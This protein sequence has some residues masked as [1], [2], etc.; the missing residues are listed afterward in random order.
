MSQDVEIH[1]ASEEERL[2]AYRNVYE[3][4]GGA[5]TLDE[6]LSRRLQSAA[7]NHAIWWV[8]KVGDQVAASLGAH[9]LE[10]SY[11]GR[12]VTGFGIAAVHTHPDHR[13]HGHAAELCRE[14][15]RHA[16]GHG[17]KLGLLFSDIDPDYY[18][19]LGYR[20]C[21]APRYLCE[22]P[23][24][25][26]ESGPLANLQPIKPA[27]ELDRLASWYDACHRKQALSIHRSD[28]YWR[29]LCEKNASA[30]YLSVGW[31]GAPA[32]GYVV[33][34]RLG[35]EDILEILELVVSDP[36]L[37]Q[38]TY[39]AA[40]QMTLERGFHRVGGWLH[41][42]IHHLNRFTAVAREKALPMLLPLDDDMTLDDELLQKGCHFWRTDHF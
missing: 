4:W 7:H 31:P 11:H 40:A 21:A 39:R 34:H 29:Y 28:A 9:P 41:P 13:R 42:A 32:E 5:R 24:D 16:T 38:G 3:F 22:Q 35:G 36:E 20:P 27:A 30:E 15:A 23:T 17:D 12:I 18:A 33:L 26:V 14:V 19:A 1:R 10:F 8:L 25:L 2:A 37:E 6:F